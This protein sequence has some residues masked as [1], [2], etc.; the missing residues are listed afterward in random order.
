MR[1]LRYGAPG[2]ER[3]GLLDAAGGIRELSGEVADIG[4]DAISPSELA[5]LA[6]LD[7]DALPRVAG[8]PRLGPPVAGVSKFVAIGLNYSDHAREAGMPIP[9]EPVVFMKA[10]SCICG[11]GDDVVQPLHS[12]KLDWEVEIAIVI[13][14]IAQY[15]SV[16]EAPS[17]IAGYC[18]ANDVS[19]RHYQLE[20]GGQWDK[21]KGFDTFGPI[22]PWLVTPDEIPDVQALDL[23]L[24][25]NGERMQSGNTGTMIFSCAQLVSYV[26]EC[27]TLNP[28]DIIT[29]GTPPGVGMGRKPPRYLK[30]GDVMTLGIG[31]LG[32]QRQRV[33]PFA[34]NER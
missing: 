19:E 6:Q 11:P 15:V 13:G 32:R 12:T 31:G 8:T 24:D 29:T 30:P 33:V 3:P 5:R 17:F 20:R 9:T 10:P 21:G 23:W 28:G 2:Q 22:G 4:G 26:S 16:A 1:L 7:I 34:A 25:V 18:I 27:M 14:A